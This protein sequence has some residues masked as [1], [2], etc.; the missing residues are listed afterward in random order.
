MRFNSR[1]LRVT[2]LLPLG[3]SVALVLALF[4][5]LFFREFSV[6]SLPV[7]LAHLAPF[8]IIF[9]VTIGIFFVAGLYDFHILSFRKRVAELIFGSGLAV[10]ALSVL[11]FYLNPGITPKTVLVLYLVFSFATISLWR[12][13]AVPKIHSRERFPALFIGNVSEGKELEKSINENSYYPFFIKEIFNAEEKLAPDHFQDVAGKENIKLLIADTDNRALDKLG[14]FFYEC[15]KL[16][17]AV[18]DS[19]R[20]YEDVLGRVPLSS[21][22]YRWFSEEVPIASRLYSVFKRSMDVVIAIP[23]FFISIIFFPFVALLIKLDDGGEIFSVQKR[24]GQGGRIM[25]LYKLRTMTFT[26]A[27]KWLEENE[28]NKVTRVGKFLR[29]SRLDELPQIVNVIFGDMSLI[30]PR[31][32]ISAIGERLKEEIPYYELRYAVPPGLSGWAQV[33]QENQPRTVEDTKVRFSY[34]LYYVKKRS[35]VLDL[36]IAFK[37]IKTLLSRTGM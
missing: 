20:F 15:H 27:G 2:F 1:A 37:T 9:L 24:M 19:T 33:R 6:P 8:A 18:L 22:S 34:D 31:P 5:A 32:D 21:L 16:G 14:K 11:F 30:G 4:L 12:F 25:R 29:T 23:L 10:L 35:L 26:D 17:R 28:E 13:F 3:D 36:H 7:F